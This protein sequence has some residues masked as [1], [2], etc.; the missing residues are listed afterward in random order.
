MIYSVS[1]VLTTSSTVTVSELPESN[2]SHNSRYDRFQ[3]IATCLRQSS[4][5]LSCHEAMTGASYVEYVRPSF[6]NRVIKMLVIYKR[7]T[8][9]LTQFCDWVGEFLRTRHVD[10]ILG[11]FNINVLGKPVA[12]LSSTLTNFIQIVKETI[13]LSRSLIDHVYIHQD[14]LRNVNADVKNFDVYFSDHDAIQ[15]SLTHKSDN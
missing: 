14:L 5:H 2:I 1:Q 3:S 4:V 9:S 10:I 7:R 12:T 13:H 6:S 8:I 11:D 15:I